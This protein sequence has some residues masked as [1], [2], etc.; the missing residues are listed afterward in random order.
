M[1]SILE[2]LRPMIKPTIHA[3]KEFIEIERILRKDSAYMDHFRYLLEEPWG[4]YE[5]EIF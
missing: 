5:A 1:K 4:L 3:L 2:S